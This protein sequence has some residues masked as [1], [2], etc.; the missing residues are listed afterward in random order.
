MHKS[1]LAGLLLPLTLAAVAASAANGQ[2]IFYA[3]DFLFTLQFRPGIDIVQDPSGIPMAVSSQGIYMAGTFQVGYAP[4]FQGLLRCYDLAGNDLYTREITATDTAFPAALAVDGVLVYVAGSVGQSRAEVFLHKY[5]ENGNLLWARQF[6][7]SD[8]YHMVS[9]MVTDP[10]GAYLAA[11][12][13]RAQGLVRKYSPQG[14][15]L[16]TRTMTVRSLRGLAL[17]GGVYV[18]GVNESGGFVTKLSTAGSELWTHQLSSSD[19]E[20]V[21]PATVAA[22]SAGVYAGGS[23]FRRDGAGGAYFPNSGEAFARRLDGDGNEVWTRRFGESGPN[24]VV[25]ISVD[26]SGVYL[27]GYGQGA[28]PGQCNAG[29]YDAF[30]RK[31]DAAGTEQWTRQFGTA[32]NDFVS[33]VAL[34]STGVYVS[35]GVRGGTAHGS[36]FVVKLGKSQAISEDARP[37]ISWECVV[38]AA[39]YAGGGIAPNEVVTILGRGIGPAKLTASPPPV[40]GRM[41][42][43]LA[44]TRILFNG[45]PA[46]LL[47]V[48]DT[49]SSAV[50]PQDVAHGNTVK[51]EVEYRGV[52]SEPL[53]LPVAAARPGIFTIDASGKGQGAI[54]NQD[55][56]LN[57]SANPATPGSVIT[58][59]ITGAGATD[60]A[61]AD[62]AVLSD[63]IAKPQL[64]VAVLFDDPTEDGT[65]SPAEVVSAE[66]VS[67]SVVGLLQVKVHLPS[68]VKTGSATAIYVEVGSEIAE[69]GVTLSVH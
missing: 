69:S 13:G 16:W 3:R 19:V 27:V 52:R 31:Y 38:N 4:A 60:P 1:A 5:D 26:S 67:G 56:S 10:S 20:I 41:D 61:V 65:V 68:W 29:Y 42:T 62:G 35:G 34:D 8:G 50:V 32:Y 59:F 37:E 53:T 14:D 40:D 9:G 30:V 64:P 25:S 57:S 51:V 49:Q 7:L 45:V 21:V 6:H 17:G 36:A 11:W 24:G 22:D 23:I 33:T 28:L 18:S 39:D 48:S 55:G 44:D 63:V 47:Y 2:A 66:S 12:D 54:L 58:L 15:E 43:T 46:P